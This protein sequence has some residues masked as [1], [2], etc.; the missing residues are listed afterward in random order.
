MA[1][2]HAGSA[3]SAPHRWWDGDSSEIYWL[4]TT[5]RPD[6]GVDLKAPQ[7]DDHGHPHASYFLIREVSVGDVVFH[8]HTRERR[9]AYWSRV[10][11]E[12]FAEDIMWASH[13]AVAREAHVRP[14]NRPGWRVLLEGPFPVS[15]PVTLA[16]LRDAESDLR[17][18]VTSIRDS[19]HRS[20]Y[21]PL[22]F[23]DRRSVRPTQFYLTKLP[24]GFVLSL[25]ALMTAADAAGNALVEELQPPP[26]KPEPPA[27]SEELGDAYVAANE[28]AA[29][30][31]RQPFAV[32]PT[33][34]DRGLR[35]HAMTQ[36]ALAAY[37]TDRGHE[38]RSP[39][40]REPQYDLAWRAGDVTFVA[41]V[42]SVTT[43][44]E[45]SQLRLG[46]GQVLRY[47]HLLREAGNTCVPVLAIER[48]PTD[49][50]WTRLCDTLC[51][52]LCWPPDFAV[53]AGT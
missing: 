20:L 26:S 30:S 24:L 12:A 40:A 25:P 6:L 52:R 46:L 4:E 2:P 41:E 11:S 15:P 21:L 35:G 31:E 50:S 5:D 53:L 9:I 37:V 39:S 45:E 23:S 22:A 49:L 8:Y 18:L 17:A 27:P 28:E 36:N 14:Y 29:S 19:S 3:I 32:D 33:L 42:K 10:A 44:N 51:V 43:S 16:D 13:G 38:P 1:S 47:A 34:V 7:T 48:L